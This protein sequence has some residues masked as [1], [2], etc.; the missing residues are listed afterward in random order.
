MGSSLGCGISCCL[1]KL[2]GDFQMEENAVGKI[3]LQKDE[4]CCTAKC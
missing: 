1:P 3:L 4:E 2:A